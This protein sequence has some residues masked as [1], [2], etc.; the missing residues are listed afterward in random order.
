MIVGFGSSILVPLQVLVQDHEWWRFA[1]L[2]LLPLRC[3]F[4]ALPCKIRLSML[5]GLPGIEWCHCGRRRCSATARGVPN[6]IIND[7]EP[8]IGSRRACTRCTIPEFSGRKL[9]I[10]SEVA[11]DVDVVVIS[12][13]HWRQR[14]DLANGV[15]DDV[16]GSSAGPSSQF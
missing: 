6:D 12:A 13:T 4:W 2:A 11:G 3:N 1:K 7:I 10:D 5:G 15:D 16:G 9:G 8:D 14:T